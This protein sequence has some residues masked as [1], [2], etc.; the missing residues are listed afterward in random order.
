M[1][2]TEIQTHFKGPVHPSENMVNGSNGYEF[3]YYLLVKT[4]TENL[5]RMHQKYTINHYKYREELYDSHNR[6]L[7]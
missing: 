3:P 2:I 4:D 1:D 6:L 5:K 7:I